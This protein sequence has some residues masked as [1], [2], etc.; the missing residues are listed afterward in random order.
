MSSLPAS[1]QAKIATTLYTLDD[2]QRFFGTCIVGRQEVAQ[3]IADEQMS[4]VK[5]IRYYIYPVNV[6][7]SSKD[8]S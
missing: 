7:S 2:V 5:V 3:L 1:V 4:Y 8:N 6:S